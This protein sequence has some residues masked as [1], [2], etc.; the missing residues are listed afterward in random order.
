VTADQAVTAGLISSDFLI[1][2]RQRLGHLFPQYY[3]A[4]FLEGSGNLFLISS[5]DKAVSLGEK[6]NPEDYRQNSIKIITVDQ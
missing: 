6:F 4:T 5:I 3:E 2:E 1:A